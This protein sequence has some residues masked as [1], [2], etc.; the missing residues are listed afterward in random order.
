M[1]FDKEHAA[2]LTALADKLKSK[3]PLLV[4]KFDYGNF[5]RKDD[6]GTV[7]CAAGESW[8]MWPEFFGRERPNC[9]WFDGHTERKL[10]EWFGLTYDEFTHLFMPRGQSPKIPGERLNS[11]ASRRKVA[12]NI[13][14]FLEYKAREQR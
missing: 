4:G 12:K 14:A 11:W 5:C 1:V 9:G 6:C 8:L 7:G 2:R 10:Q 3:E 13:R